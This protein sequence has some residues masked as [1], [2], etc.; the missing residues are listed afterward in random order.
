MKVIF[1]RTW[2]TLPNILIMLW[3]FIIQ[4][5]AKMLPVWIPWNKFHAPLNNFVNIG[6]SDGLISLIK[7][8]NLYVCCHLQQ[9]PSKPKYPK[10]HILILLFLQTG[11][12]VSS[13]V[14]SA[15]FK[16]NSD[17]LKSISVN[18]KCK[19]NLYLFVIIWNYK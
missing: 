9:D 5:T 14:S 12:M 16:S 13:R 19:K 1:P 8:A 15:K 3:L 7:W 2:K 17:L 18:V 6:T 11:I 10:Y 4:E